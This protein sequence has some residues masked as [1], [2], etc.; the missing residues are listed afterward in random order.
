MQALEFTVSLLE[1]DQIP[2]EIVT[3]FEGLS[4][5]QLRKPPSICVVEIYAVR[6]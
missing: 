3:S 1:V 6:L 5:M 4:L 2:K